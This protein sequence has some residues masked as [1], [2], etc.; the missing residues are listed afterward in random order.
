MSDFEDEISCS[1]ND[2]NF[3]GYCSDGDFE[4]EEIKYLDTK[5]PNLSISQFSLDVEELM[6][7]DVYI[8]KV[9][10][11][12]QT[13]TFEYHCSNIPDY[14]CPI[15]GINTDT[16]MVFSFDFG[17]T[18]LVGKQRPTY[19]VENA[20]TIEYQL[21]NSIALFLDRHHNEYVSAFK[22][23]SYK[24]Y[25]GYIISI[26]KRI[27]DRILHPGNYCINCDKKHKHEGLVPISCG[28]DL[29]FFQSTELGL[30]QDLYSLIKI[31]PDVC[32][33]LLCF[34]YA[35]CN[36][37]HRRNIVFPDLPEQLLSLCANDKDKTYELI[38]EILNKIPSI[39]EMRK[40]KDE[41]ALKITLFNIHKAASYLIRWIITTA[42]SHLEFIDKSDKEFKKDC[43]FND[44]EV[45]GVFR[46]LSNPPEK[47]RKFNEYKKKEG[48]QIHN[49]Y[50][51]SPIENWHSIIRTSLK[52]YSGHQGK[53][54]HG[55]AYGNGV[56]LAPDSRTSLGYMGYKTS[57]TWKGS[58][59]SNIKCMVYCK[60]INDSSDGYKK[61]GPYYV[62]PND[63]LIRTEYLIVL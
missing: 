53:Q 1:D 58:N 9:F 50:H 57:S 13:I 36:N 27:R 6:L 54:L 25:T 28:S 38:L 10:S 2:S 51:G 37:K 16:T 18:Y 4:V 47:E 14:L 24:S 26:Y 21:T 30:L 22:N 59:Y 7:E 61:N 32:D 3:S 11:C 60:I 39:N 43:D 20:G 23:G 56:Y 46:Y 12:D 15:I 31:K 29:C 62:I 40:D 34:T 55:A 35:T 41:D 44:S 45:K 5:N 49:G 48:I 8:S 63:D 33:I 52:N 19:K 17:N 42:N